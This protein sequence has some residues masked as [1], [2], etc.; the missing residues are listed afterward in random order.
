MPSDVTFRKKLR[1]VPVSTD[2]IVHALAGVVSQF[3]NA[4]VPVDI[5]GGVHDDGV[6]D[7]RLAERIALAHAL[8]RK[9]LGA[10]IPSLARGT[11]PRID[12]LRRR[13]RRT[14]AARR[15]QSAAQ[16]G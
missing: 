11:R 10:W 14:F 15:R 12:A 2:E 3:R 8:G 16:R 1:D 7:A 5:L 9:P 4:A 13:R 6:D